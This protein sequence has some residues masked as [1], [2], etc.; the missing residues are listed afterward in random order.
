MPSLE[1]GVT[2]GATGTLAA[3]IVNGAKADVLLAA[4]ADAPQKLVEQNIAASGD[5]FVFA[6]GRLVVWMSAHAR[7]DLANLG[8]LALADPAVRRIAIPNPRHAPYGR[9]AEQALARYELVAALN[10]RLIRGENA[11]QAAQFAAGGAVDAALLPRSLVTSPALADGK[12]W[13]VPAD[14]HAPIEHVGLVLRQ[15]QDRSAADAVVA[16]LRSPA[17]QAI[18]ERRG[19]DPVPAG[20]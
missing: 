17:G 20:R 15:A 19:L 8:L 7:V 2:T 11:E 9:A 13:L 16:L 12:T 14:A 1:V 6:R 5:Q 10:G 3:Q 18:L 4:D